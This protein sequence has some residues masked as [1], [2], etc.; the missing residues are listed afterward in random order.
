M[1]WRELVKKIN[2]LPEDQLDLQAIVHL[3]EQDEEF[4]VDNLA[5]DP[6]ANW[7]YPVIFVFN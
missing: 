4:P 6:K 5:S 3:E 7:K 1:T 2:E